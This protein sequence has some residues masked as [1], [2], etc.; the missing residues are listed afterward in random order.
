MKVFMFFSLNGIGEHLEAYRAMVYLRVRTVLSHVFCYVGFY[1]SFVLTVLAVVLFRVD[2]R[3]QRKIQ[4]MF[5]CVIANFAGKSDF[6]I[7]LVAGILFGRFNKHF[8]D[9]P[10]FSMEICVHRQ[11]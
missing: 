3:M 7:V 2:F 8:V 6:L 11:E 1:A 10:E 9:F 4:T 5:G